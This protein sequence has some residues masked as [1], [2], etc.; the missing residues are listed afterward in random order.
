MRAEREVCPG[1]NRA[2]PKP[3]K[4]RAASLETP[5]SRFWREAFVTFAFSQPWPGGPRFVGADPTFRPG[6]LRLGAT[7]GEQT[8][9]AW[10]A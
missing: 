1:C 7:G 10:A 2:L 3:R 9:K 4:P 5:Y 8:A 6:I